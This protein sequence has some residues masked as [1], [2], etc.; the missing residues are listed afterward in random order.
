M[1]FNF[2]MFNLL[3]KWPKGG[4]CISRQ[5]LQFRQIAKQFLYGLDFVNPLTLFYRES[6]RNLFEGE[7]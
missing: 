1:P 7:E 2:V 6:S 4:F 3:L 5:I